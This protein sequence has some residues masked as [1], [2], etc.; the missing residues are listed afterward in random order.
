MTT[1][2]TCCCRC[3][4]SPPDCSLARDP[5]AG[6]A[7]VGPRRSV[8][9]AR[10]ALQ[11]SAATRCRL[12]SEPDLSPGSARRPLRWLDFPRRRAG[13]VRAAGG[14]G[15][16]AHC[17]S[18]RLRPFRRLAAVAPLHPVE[19]PLAVGPR[20]AGRPSE[21]LQGLDPGEC[22]RDGAAGARS[23]SRRGGAR[24]VS[25]RAVRR[26]ARR[27]FGRGLGGRDF[28]HGR[29]QGCEI[30]HDAHRDAPDAHAGL[31]VQRSGR[32]PPQ[33]HHRTASATSGRRSRLEAPPAP[34]PPPERAP[35]P[36][37][38]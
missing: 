4:C 22:C 11:T 7:A 16:R 5:A 34:L 1:R 31:E 8:A 10:E 20:A 14:F 33:R 24:R 30:D 29:R 9:A 18:A 27:G 35:A 6:V 13:R 2:H 36:A 38:E 28:D 17:L 15:R 23:D 37:W 19:V 25:A 12:R 32:L 21:A 3:R 26:A